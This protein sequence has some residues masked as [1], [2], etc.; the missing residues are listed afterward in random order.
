MTSEGASRN[1]PLARLPSGR[2]RLTREAVHDSQRQRLLL[3]IAQVVAEKGFAAATVADVVNRASV[4]RSTFYQHFQDKESCFL[5]SFNYAVGLVIEQMREAWEA[6]D[7][8]EDW[9]AHLR[10]DLTTFLRA[11]AAEPAFA[12][13][14]HVEVL[15][16][17]PAALERRAEILTLFTERTRRNH[18][19]A[20]TQ[21][22]RLPELP[23]EVFQMH[24]GG[25]DELIREHARTRGPESLTELIEPAVAATLALFGDTR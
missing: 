2:H 15:A 6:L 7:A 11:L 4:S 8:G 23:L 18:V 25:L 5:A 9:R 13:A 16:A 21:E 17:G 12:R 20:R 3:A 1:P 10:S 24:T 14:L 22:P 19:L